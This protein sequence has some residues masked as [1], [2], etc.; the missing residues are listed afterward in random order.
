MTRSVLTNSTCVAVLG[1]FSAGL[2]GAAELFLVSA[3]GGNSTN[4]VYRFSVAGAASAATLTLTIA[5][6]NLLQPIGI[7]F[8]GSG[9]MFVTN[10]A[11]YGGVPSL[12]ISHQPLAT[13]SV[14]DSTYTDGTFHFPHGVKVWHNQLFVLQTTETGSPSDPGSVSRYS[15]QPNQVP[16]F[17]DSIP[18]LGGQA[19]W[20]AVHPTTG[21]V[22]VTQCCGA[23]RIDRFVLNS[24]GNYVPNGSISGNGLANPHGMTFSSSGELFVANPDW[25]T[26]SRFKF[27]SAGI[28]TPSGNIGGNYGAI[29][30]AFSP[31]G[32]L[33]VSSHLQP[34]V[35]RWTFDS[36]GDAIS[37]GSFSTPQTLGGLAFYPSGLHH[38][39][40][41]YD[42]AKA[43]RSGSTLPVKLQLCDGNGNDVSSPTLSLHATAVSRVLDS[44]SGPVE[45]S[46]NANPDNDFRFDTSLGPTGGYI[47]NLSTKGLSTGTY[48][49]NFTVSGDSFVYSAPFQVK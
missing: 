31:W 34:A 25:G 9:A 28:A 46:G 24:S 44:I 16:L 38:I 30:V 32:E 22:F 23:N 4:E 3:Q 36:A 7:T 10:R 1:L 42:S 12:A 37:N 6:P 27:D 41:L 20:V 19:R 14:F 49:L 2:C 18:N 35:Y 39:C 26:V 15:L 48:N 47:F 29:D 17:Q 45:D 33:F 11:S 43:V 5:D 21:E 8:D 40:L 13:S